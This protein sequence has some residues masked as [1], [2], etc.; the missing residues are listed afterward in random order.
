MNF[1][2]PMNQMLWSVY[3]SKTN[4]QYLQTRDHIKTLYMSFFAIDSLFFQSLP[5]CSIKCWQKIKNK[6]EKVLDALGSIIRLWKKSDYSYFG[7][8]RVANEV[9]FFLLTFTW[10]FPIL[11]IVHMTNLASAKSTTKF[12][13]K[14]NN[15]KIPTTDNMQHNPVSFVYEFITRLFGIHANCI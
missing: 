6:W 5:I 13:I 7:P 10:N 15:F 12:H 4:R 9:S 14:T 8:Y 11:P 1:Q 2:A 3:M